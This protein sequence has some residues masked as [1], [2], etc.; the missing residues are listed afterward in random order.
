MTIAVL[1]KRSYYKLAR[2]PR[3]NADS[4]PEH[5]IFISQAK[6]HI[7]ATLVNFSRG[8][9]AMKVEKSNFIVAPETILSK[10]EFRVLNKTFY[11][12]KMRVAHFHKEHDISVFGASVAE[13]EIAV[14]EIIKIANAQKEAQKI[15]DRVSQKTSPIRPS[16]MLAVLELKAFFKEMKESLNEW[17]EKEKSQ[18]HLLKGEEEELLTDLFPYFKEET[19]KKLQVMAKTH[20]EFLENEKQNHKDFFREHLHSYFMEAPF[21]K[22]SFEKPRGYP[23]DYLMMDMIYRQEFIGE[24]IFGR[25]MN[26]FLTTYIPCKANTE[27]LDYLTRLLNE[28]STAVIKKGPKLVKIMSLGSGP[29]REIENFLWNYEVSDYCEFTCVDWDEEAI[30][31][32]RKK[33]LNAKDKA[34]RKTVI[35]FIHGDVVAMLR[36]KPM[37][38]MKGQDLIYASGLFDY[39]TE[40]IAKRIVK[41]FYELLKGEGE[42]LIVNATVNDPSIMET[43]YIGEWVLNRR[44]NQDLLTLTSFLP[45]FAEHSISIDSQGVYSYLKVKRPIKVQ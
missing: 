43:E 26:K 35:H 19:T 14:D 11:S 29:A 17:I 23:G 32:A 2:A 45:P 22:R 20:A 4:L 41:H 34:K 8:G 33:I 12:G 27:R 39:L 3:Y 24:T 37:E 30:E 42:L 38:S 1:N 44:S 40:S 18:W 7:P 28:V 13:K 25:L 5:S 10:V 6:D 21:A 36:D 31:F 16:F 15:I 9:L